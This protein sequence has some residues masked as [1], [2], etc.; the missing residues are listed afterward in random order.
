MPVIDYRC[1][2]CQHIDSRFIPASQCGNAHPESEVSRCSRCRHKSERVYDYQE[3]PHSIGFPEIV[4]HLNTKTGEYSIPGHRDE[5]LPGRGY[6]RVSI[7]SFKQYEKVRSSVDS[8]LREEAQFKQAIENQYFDLSS[9]SH[10]ESTRQRMES[11]ISKGG[12]WVQST[13]EKGITRTRWA[14]ITQRA[15]LLFEISCRQADAKRERIRSRVSSGANFHSRIL[16][17]RES[18]RSVIS[19]AAKRPE[20]PDLRNLMERYGNKHRG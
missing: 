14:P 6:K 17:H 3:A 19:G 13:D 8:T 15:R 9:K 11:A 12:H 2:H 10:R 4:M 1:R 16:E 20:M 5:E 7:T 18:E